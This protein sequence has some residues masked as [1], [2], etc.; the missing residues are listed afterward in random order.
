MKTYQKRNYIK[1]ILLLTLVLASFS[2]FAQTTR[3]SLAK[4]KISGITVEMIK[5]TEPSKEDLVLVFLTYQ[6]QKYSTISD[7]ASIMLTDSTDL[8]KF[9]SDLQACYDFMDSGEK[10]KS[11][12]Y[13]HERYGLD[14]FDFSPNLY[15][16]DETGRKYISVDKKTVKALIEFMQTLE[17]P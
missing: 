17:F 6:N 9:N 14:I 4:K 8:K 11:I 5:K 12:S 2:L 13:K 3:E 1:H 15:I 7:I 10:G 16:N